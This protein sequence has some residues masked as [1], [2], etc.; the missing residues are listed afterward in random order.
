M[1]LGIYEMLQ[2][3]RSY[4][5]LFCKLGVIG[6]CVLET[7]ELLDPP[8]MSS[9]WKFGLM[10]DDWLVKVEE[11]GIPFCEL[12]SEIIQLEVDLLCTCG[13]TLR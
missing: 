2:D 9:T 8:E 4:I 12:D 5:Y 11:N 1:P 3:A 13:F 6:C 10:C 7:R